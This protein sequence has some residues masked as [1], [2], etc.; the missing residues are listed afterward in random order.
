MQDREKTD[1]FDI[2]KMKGSVS[3]ENASQYN[4]RRR[5]LND[6][7]IFNDYNAQE[8]EGALYGKIIEE[9]NV[10]NCWEERSRY[11]RGAVY[12]CPVL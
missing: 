9:G 8:L 1:D 3:E 10:L 7:S 2:L 4:D 11:A 6:N 5:V 12:C